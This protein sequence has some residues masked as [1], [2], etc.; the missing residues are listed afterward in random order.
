MR[1]RAILLSG[2]LVVFGVLTWIIG[3]KLSSD[4]MG[5][6]VG[7]LFGAL[8]GIPSALL[9]LATA[10]RAE[11]DEEDRYRERANYERRQ[12]GYQLPPPVIILASGPATR[13]PE[14]RVTFPGE[15]MGDN[16][17]EPDGSRWSID[18]TGA[19]VRYWAEQE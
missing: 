14:A 18:R 1:I 15:K 6:A 12:P 8:A 11:P 17:W 16:R 19:Q 9:V 2:V 4:A 10:R 13:P 5:M 7:L 3:S